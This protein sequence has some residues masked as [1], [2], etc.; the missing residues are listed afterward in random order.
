MDLIATTGRG[1]LRPAPYPLDFVIHTE[2]SSWNHEIPETHETRRRSDLNRAHRLGDSG[3]SRKG[4][5]FRVFRVFRCG[6]RR[7]EV[8]HEPPPFSPLRQFALRPPISDFPPP[9]SDL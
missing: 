4:F 2:K 5:S 8:N 3:R 9:T 6:N 1:W 7:N